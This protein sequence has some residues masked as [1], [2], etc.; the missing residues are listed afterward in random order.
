MQPQSHLYLSTKIHFS[1]SK[2]MPLGVI[3][4]PALAAVPSSRNTAPTTARQDSCSVIP[5]TMI[6]DDIRQEKLDQM[7]LMH[8]NKTHKKPNS[9]HSRQLLAAPEELVEKRDLMGTA[10]G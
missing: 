4:N 2:K 3:M 7:L 6:K 1:V 10:D 5:K 9:P 8:H